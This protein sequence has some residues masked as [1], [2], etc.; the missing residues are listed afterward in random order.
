M[1]TEMSEKAAK[2]YEFLKEDEHKP[3]PV[4]G[5]TATLR[6]HAISAVAREEGRIQ[7]YGWSLPQKS[8][9]TATAA[10]K[11][12][13]PV[14]VYCR[15]LFQHD[16]QLKLSCAATISFRHD[17]SLLKDCDSLV[18]ASVFSHFASG[19]DEFKS[20]C[21]W[22]CN[23]NANDTHVSV[24]DANKPGE[25]LQQ[26]T[27]IGI[28]A[29][30]VQ[31]VEGAHVSE[32]PLSGEKLKQL[33]ANLTEANNTLAIMRNEQPQP[34]TQTAGWRRGDR[35]SPGHTAHR[36]AERARSDHLNSQQQQ[37]FQ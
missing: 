3:P 35:W 5:S 13:I 8:S 16:S 19:S 28:K 20:S 15:P 18:E 33:A 37:P 24:L 29:L 30:C 6:H 32:Y 34:A 12:S 23:L 27:L 14:P 17:T 25:I 21:I 9:P 4:K 7:A 2:A 26:F 36:G 10:S 1:D 11:S 31:S 22:I